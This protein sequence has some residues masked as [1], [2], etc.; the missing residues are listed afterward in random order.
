MRVFMQGIASNDFV[1][2]PNPSFF[3]VFMNPKV[4]I[5]AMKSAIGKTVL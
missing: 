3:S 4:A 5:L 1:K 2:N